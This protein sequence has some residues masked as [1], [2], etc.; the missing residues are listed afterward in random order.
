[1]A[2]PMSMDGMEH[3]KETIY[4]MELTSTS[5]I[6]DRDRSLLGGFNC[7]DNKDLE[8]IVESKRQGADLDSTLALLYQT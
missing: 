4:L 1:M 6:R 7:T 2:I 3:S 5:S 8:V